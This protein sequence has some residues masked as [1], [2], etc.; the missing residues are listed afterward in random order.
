MYSLPLSNPISRSLS[1]NL[2]HGHQS[3]LLHSPN[4][5]PSLQN[6]VPLNSMSNFSKS[7]STTPGSSHIRLESP[8]NYNIPLKKRMISNADVESRK[9]P[10]DLSQWRETRVLA[11]RKNFKCNDELDSDLNFINYYPGDIETV[12][13]TLV[14]VMYNEERVTF[15][16]SKDE[17]RFSLIEDAQARLDKLEKGIL[18]LFRVSNQNVSCS[19]HSSTPT[20]VPLPTSSGL[21]DPSKSQKATKYRLGRII[22]K[23]KNFLVEPICLEFGSNSLIS[24]L[25]NHEWIDRPNLRLLQPP[26]FDEYKDELDLK[27]NL[28]LIE[29]LKKFLSKQL[30]LSNKCGLQVFSGSTPILGFPAESSAKLVQAQND[31]KEIQTNSL[32]LNLDNYQQTNFN[33]NT[34]YKKGDIVT[35]PNGIRKK[36]NGKQWR[37]LCSKEDC[38]KESQRKG[39]CSRHLTQRSG[40]RKVQNSLATSSSGMVQAPFNL[41][42]EKEIAF[43]IGSMNLSKFQNSGSFQSI[44]SSKWLM[45][46]YNQMPKS[47]LRTDDE[48]CAANA[49]VG[50]NSSVKSERSNS[51]QSKTYDT[52][53]ADFYPDTD[54]ENE[55]SDE[56]EE[57]E[58]KE[59]NEVNADNSSLS[60]KKSPSFSDDDNDKNNGTGVL[61]VQEDLDYQNKDSKIG[62]SE[63]KNESKKSHDSKSAKCLEQIENGQMDDNL[64]RENEKKAKM[65]YLKR[66]VSDHDLNPPGRF[67]FAN[68]HVRRPMNAFMIFSKKERP[69]IHQQHPNCD[70]RAVSKMLGE[71]WYALDQEEKNFYHQ[72]ASQLKKDHFKANPEWKWRNKLERQKSEPG[73][74]V[75]KSKK[76]KDFFIPKGLRKQL[77]C[78]SD[79]EDL[80]PNLTNEIFESKIKPKPIKQILPVKSTTINDFNN[81]KPCGIVFKPTSSSTWTPSSTSLD[82]EQSSPKISPLD[83]PHSPNKFFVQQNTTFSPDGIGSKSFSSN[84]QSDRQPPA[85]LYD[86]ELINDPTNEIK[87]LDISINHTDTENQKPLRKTISDSS[88]FRLSNNKTPKSALL[89][90]RRKAVYNLLKQSIYPSVR[91]TVLKKYNANTIFTSH[92]LT[93]NVV[94]NSRLLT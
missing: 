13:G 44:N 31:P 79:I 15:D 11:L 81:F 63:N 77:S 30:Q 70:N 72:V 33:A 52:T 24:E 54:L 22:E 5:A 34:K 14:T 2:P 43:N 67:S 28:S 88:L 76:S 41:N 71:R 73:T 86:S 56:E 64:S 48:L 66:N 60:G 46:D 20:S 80:I 6:P 92:C 45:Q 35:T 37:R 27:L 3:L 85:G 68:E 89:E 36:F 69:L 25:V 93:S 40:G 57:E 17:E 7:T 26:W 49:L 74:K 83:Q 39:F 18:V 78:P 94:F 90:K 23:Q 10:V 82:E 55:N 51:S 42:P 65:T 84:F 9:F 19:S 4:M 16:V 1:S 38:S 12:N 62:S 87:E 8:S 61:L 91:A 29:S 59:D 47:K 50:I 75:L 21:V 58:E 32:N 53:S